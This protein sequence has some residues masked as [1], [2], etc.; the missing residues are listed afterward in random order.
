MRR[1][2]FGR[3]SPRTQ[4]G[5]H[6]WSRFIYL[7]C[8]G[9]GYLILL[10]RRLDKPISRRKHFWLKVSVYILFF[11]VYCR[12]RIYCIDLQI[13]KRKWQWIGCTLRKDQDAVMKLTLSQNP[14]GQREKGRPGEEHLGPELGKHGQTRQKNRLQLPI[15][16]VGAVSFKHYVP[17]ESD[18]ELVQT[19]LLRYFHQ[20]R[21]YIVL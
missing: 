9:R 21:Y 18:R 16:C 1:A 12:K 20:L 10:F 6:V 19:L 17:K 11:V 8:V 4:V 3:T 14:Q 5:S 2:E 15:V 13:K 7:L